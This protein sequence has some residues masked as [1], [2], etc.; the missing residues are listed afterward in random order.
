MTLLVLVGLIPFAALGILLGHLVSADS[1]GPAIG[2][3]TA[4]LAF[5]GGVWFPLGHPGVL[6]EI[7]QALPSYWL[8]QAAHVGTGGSGWGLHGWAVLA[9]W[10]AAASIL[11]RRAYVRDT[12][13]A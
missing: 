8:V 4:L 12:K 11:G 13:R 3:L 10:A 6:L 9:A 7:G 1:V 5:L 2:G